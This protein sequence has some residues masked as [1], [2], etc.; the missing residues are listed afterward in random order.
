MIMQF[1][2][3]YSECR[4]FISATSEPESPSYRKVILHDESLF[5]EWLEL[6]IELNNFRYTT[7]G[8]RKTIIVNG[9]LLLKQLELFKKQRS[10]EVKNKMPPPNILEEVLRV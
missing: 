8:I 10:L 1:Y 6:E 9:N 2:A 5:N 3:N 7:M 4:N